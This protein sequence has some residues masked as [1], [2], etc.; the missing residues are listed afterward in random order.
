MLI[1]TTEY[2]KAFGIQGNTIR[3]FEKWAKLHELQWEGRGG[4]YLKQVE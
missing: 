2:E 3:N 4:I 1:C